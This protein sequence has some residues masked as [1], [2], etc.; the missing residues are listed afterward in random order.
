MKNIFLLS[1][2]IFIC[3][4]CSSSKYIL[5]ESP[6]YLKDKIILS[7][8]NDSIYFNINLFTID[9]YEN[10]CYNF[11][12]QI[13]SINIKIKS[14]QFNKDVKIYKNDINIIG[15]PSN[16]E[17]N[18]IVLPIN[19]KY[20][21]TEKNINNV[22]I[23]LD[24][25]YGLNY[26]RTQKEIRLNDNPEILS[27]F[28]VILNE[29][30]KSIEFAVLAVRNKIKEEFIPS[31]EELRLEVLNFKGRQIYS[32]QTGINFLQIILPVFPENIGNYYLY[33]QTW[34][35]KTDENNLVVPGKYTI[36]LMI[37]ALPT[38]YK[39]NLTLEK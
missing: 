11:F 30:D 24:I 25:Y 27:L 3:F 18:T 35:F 20:E 38:P 6:D 2:C 37:P 23:I 17:G 33:K 28:P 31:S 39:V 29:N 36:N 22:S 9:K 19:L 7:Q 21:L 10:L 13:D 14:E 34:D 15:I 32:S 1:F 16:I 12:K 8:Q 26:I 4:S 5:N